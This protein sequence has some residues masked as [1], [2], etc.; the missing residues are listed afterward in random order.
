[1]DDKLTLLAVFAHP[2]D[3]AFGVG[4]TLCRYARRGDR[5]SPGHSHPRRGGADIT[6]RIGQTTRTFLPSV[7][8][9]CVAPCATYGIHPPILLDYVDGQLTIVPPRTGRRQAGAPAAQSAGRRS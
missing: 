2:D 5:R 7:S 4:G 6:P 3:E 8:E 1:M 9:S